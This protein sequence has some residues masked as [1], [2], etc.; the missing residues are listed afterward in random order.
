MDSRTVG[1]YLIFIPL[2]QKMGYGLFRINELILTE[3][4]EVAV[5]SSKRFA[6]SIMCL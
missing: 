3:A 1:P 4:Q 5:A 2:A 6:R